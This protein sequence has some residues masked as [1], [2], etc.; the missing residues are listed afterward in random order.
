MPHEA[1]SGGSGAWAL[2]SLKMFSRM[3]SEFICAIQAWELSQSVT[4]AVGCVAA[5]ASRIKTATGMNSPVLGSCTWQV[6]LAPLSKV[7]FA[8]AAIISTERRL[9]AEHSALRTSSPVEV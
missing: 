8:I 5:L 7:V 9:R 6:E 2:P 3:L 1:R 4:P